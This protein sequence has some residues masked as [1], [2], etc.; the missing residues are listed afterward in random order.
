MSGIGTEM[1]IFVHAVLTG[2]F[3]ASV[4]LSLRVI[5][6]LVSH[7]LWVLNLED[8]V[9]WIFTSL[10]LFVQIYHTSDGVIRWPFVLGV[11]VGVVI[12]LVLGHFAQKI[13]QKIYDLKQKKEGKSVEKFNQKR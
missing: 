2:I 4:Y 9:Y 11:V 1:E 3:A 5:R 13:E 7:A 10:Y 12:M 8:A 6:R